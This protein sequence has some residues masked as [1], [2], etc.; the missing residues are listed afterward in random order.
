MY[1]DQN[2]PLSQQINVMNEG[3]KKNPALAQKTAAI[4][5]ET[6][7]TL[8]AKRVVNEFA[9]QKRQLQEES[10]VGRAGDPNTT[11]NDNLKTQGVQL[12]QDVTNLEAGRAKAAGDVG[13]RQQ[14]DQQNAL[15]KLV[16]ANRK[17][18]LGGGIGNI[19]NNPNA[20]PS[21]NRGGV[22]TLGANNMR[23]MPPGG[24]TP[25]AQPMRAAQGG[26][27]KF[28]EGGNK[29]LETEEQTPADRTY[30]L[31]NQFRED[32]K[33]EAKAEADRIIKSFEKE[34]RGGVFSNDD[35]QRMIDFGGAR[36]LSEGFRQSSS[37]ANMREAAERKEINDA[38]AA[39][40][41]GGNRLSTAAMQAAIS[42]GQLGLAEERL[43]QEDEQFTEK[44]NYDKFKFNETQKLEIDKLDVNEAQFKQTLAE[45]V[46][47]RELREKIE[48]GKLG[49]D[50]AY[51]KAVVALSNQ[52]NIN[53]AKGLVVRLAA[54]KNEYIQLM[55]T[56][57]AGSSLSDD[58]KE[59]EM[60]KLG[61]EYTANI[62]KLT[63][64]IELNPSTQV[65]MEV[66]EKAQEMTDKVVKGKK[67]GGIA[68]L[69]R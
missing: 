52:E 59:I 67:R 68:S 31:I 6:M 3:F 37:A 42:S 55:Q 49:V 47:D 16:A 61:A 27:V 8:I 4:P 18:S 43:A 14:M 39:G 36:T 7:E 58:Q 12:A 26:V 48:A 46:Q 2:D 41:Q 32:E 30:A 28:D 64:D 15:N 25:N 69:A 57:I 29:G 5:P 17:P 63:K 23:G 13:R 53:D 21:P 1:T 45:K 9:R 50:R 51:K 19:L 11:V 44:L 65:Q 60:T 62:L 35:I 22:P 20:A 34:E 38:L 66:D 24:I 56:A 33:A 10:F 54:E 40:R